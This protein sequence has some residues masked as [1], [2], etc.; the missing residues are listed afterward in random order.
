MFRLEGE[1]LKMKQATP[2]F[3]RS[4]RP[5][6]CQHRKS[7]RDDNNPNY[8]H[9][10]SHKA[11]HTKSATP[12]TQEKQAP[13]I[14]PPAKEQ[15]DIS[16]E[17]KLQISRQ[18]RETN[19]TFR[20][21]WGTPRNCTPAMLEKALLPLLQTGDSAQVTIKRSFR[22]HNNKRKWWFT[23]TAPQA[24]M[25]LIEGVWPSLEQKKS[26]R[27]QSSLK[28]PVRTVSLSENCDHFNQQIPALKQRA[29]IFPKRP[30]IQPTSSLT[31]VT[32]CN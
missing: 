18:V 23:I 15:K 9:K 7:Q 11:K 5:T 30:M 10:P 25:A 14:A 3:N 4:N 20:I 26:W 6:K 28:P 1:I 12:V 27:L 16:T 13:E 8:N 24:T 31:A 32:R 29:S 19:T 2:G 17:Q 22:T 21:V